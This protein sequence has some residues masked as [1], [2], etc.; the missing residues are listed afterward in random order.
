MSDVQTVLLPVGPDLYAVPIEWAREVLAAP[1]VTRLATAPAVVLGLI[2]LRGEIIPLL[3]SAALLGVGTIDTVAFAAVL[4]TPHGPAALAATGLPRRA[5]LGEPTG[6]SELPGTAG[7][8]TLDQ[9]L[10][11]LLDPAV[12]LTPERVSGQQMFA[13]PP[14]VGVS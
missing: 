10:A 2:N 1:P 13:L 4:Q 8:Y 11:V 14:A 3:D 9:G 6:P 12:L 5:E 7:N